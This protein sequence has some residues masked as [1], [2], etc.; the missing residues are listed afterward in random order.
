MPSQFRLARRTRSFDVYRRTGPVP[1][2]RTL[3]EGPVAAVPLNCATPEGRAIVAGGGVAA[4][5]GPYVSVT[6]PPIAPGDTVTVALPLTP[7]RWDLVTPYGGPLPVEVS[8]PGV[9]TTLPAN[10][11]RPGPRWP[12]GRV[13][14]EKPGDVPVTIHPQGEWLTPDSALT[15]MTTVAA[16]PVGSEHIVPI[17]SAC[18]LLVDWYR[19][20]RA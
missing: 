1:P 11:D 17:A 4:V 3:A 9:R 16:V 14:V 20:A 19:P 2:R 7:G 10:L 8:A 6:V 12:I 15:Y 5:R 18:G 13:T